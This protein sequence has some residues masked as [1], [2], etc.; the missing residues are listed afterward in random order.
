MTTSQEE[1]VELPLQF[2]KAFPITVW[3]SPPPL[4]SV[5]ATRVCLLIGNSE[6]LLGAVYKSARHALSDADVIELSSFRHKS[7]LAGDMNGKHPFWNSIVP[8][9]SREK[10]N[11][12][13]INE[14]EISV[15]QCP[16]YCCPAGNN[17][18]LDIVVRKNVQLSEVIFFDILDSDRLPIVFHLLDHV[19]T[20]NISDLVDKFADWEQFQS[21]A[22]QLISPRIQIN[23]GEEADKVVCD[24][25]PSIALAYRL[26]TSK[27]TLLDLNNDLPGLESLL[28]HKWR[29]RKLWQVTQD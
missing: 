20:G 4:I 17:D 2:E 8:N 21:L 5:E 26:S 1:K 15:S 25:T 14:F 27:I 9:P 13:D 22:S 3:T 10:L 28:K 12:L 23:L 19:R 11:L 6:M 7:L 29:L 24:F 16:T 18:V